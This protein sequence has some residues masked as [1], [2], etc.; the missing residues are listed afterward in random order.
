MNNNGVKDVGETDYQ[1]ATMTLSGAASAT[2]TTD[3]SGNY[4]FANLFADTY[5]L[6]L[7]VP[8]RYMATT[9]NPQSVVIG[10]NTTANFGII[11]VY[12]VTGNVFSDVN[13]NQLKDGGESNYTGSAVTISSSGGSVSV[14]NG[15]YTV[16]NLIQGTYTISYTSP[17]PTGFQLVYPKNGPPPS[18]VVTVGPGCTTDTTTGASCTAQQ[19]IINL[20]FSISDAIPWVQTSGLDARFDPGVTNYIAATPACSGPYALTNGS[21]SNPGVLFV[22]D[23]AP[24][25]GYGSSS[26]TKQVVGGAGYPEVYK[27]TKGNLSSSYSSLLALMQKSS[28]SIIDI[29]SLNGCS[30]LSNCSLPNN[31]DTGIYQANG[32]VVLHNN[33]L[34][35]N[36]TYIFLINGTLTITENVQVPQG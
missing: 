24:N 28:S 32:D 20:N 35:N 26:S 8:A 6:T 27:S 15:A 11:P 25:Y 33:K 7:T 10:P 22:G 12:T 9:T 17:L 30:N 23:T 3:A 18:F 29:Q 31:L 19:D 34:K 4:T 14:S 2:T 5:L 36:S 13:K 16:I 21:S 1:N